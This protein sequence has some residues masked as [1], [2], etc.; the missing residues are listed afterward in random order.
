MATFKKAFSWFKHI[1]ET[2]ISIYWG[3]YSPHKLIQDILKVHLS[4]GCSVMPEIDLLAADS[5]NNSCWIKA[6]VAK[7]KKGKFFSTN[8]HYNMFTVAAIFQTLLKK[9]NKFL[10]FFSF[11]SYGFFLLQLTGL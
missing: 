5:D 6:G 7:H 9:K 4:Y 10:I 11:L 2:N 3:L 1:W 8:L